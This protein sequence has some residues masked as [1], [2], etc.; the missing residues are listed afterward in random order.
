M[1]AGD[2]RLRP[3][4]DL[5]AEGRYDVSDFLPPRP[6]GTPDV[7]EELDALRATDPGFARVRVAVCYPGR[8][9]APFLRPY[10]TDP[11]AARWPPAPRSP[12]RRPPGGRRPSPRTGR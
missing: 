2:D 9:E 11:Q 10:L 7:Y 4:W 3:L 8:A 12:M 5:F 1:W 6:T